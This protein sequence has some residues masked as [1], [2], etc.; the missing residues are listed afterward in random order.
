MRKSKFNLLSYVVDEMLI[1]YESSN[2]KKK[3]GFMIAEI[4]EYNQII[5]L[6]NKFIM[7]RYVKYYSIQICLKKTKKIYLFICF[8]DDDKE[9]LVKFHNVLIDRIHQI[10]GRILILN[11]DNLEAAFLNIFVENISFDINIVPKSNT[12]LLDIE[13]NPIILKFYSVDLDVIDEKNSFIPNFEDF[14]ISRGLESNLV[15]NFFFDTNNTIMVSCY[16]T[17]SI[18][19]NEIQKDFLNQTNNFFNITLLKK[20]KT[21]LKTLGY[22]LWRYKIFEEKAFFED[23][24]NLFQL[25]QKFDFNNL[26]KLNIQFEQ[27]LTKNKIDFNRINDN[28]LLINDTSLFITIIKFNPKIL[29]EILKKYYSKYYIYLFVPIKEIHKKLYAIEKINLLN[30][31]TILDKTDFLKLEFLE[32]FQEIVTME[33]VI[34]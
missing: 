2:K 14:L 24:L 3:I 34:Y 30:K 29:L 12:I 23:C 15:F 9:R 1:F 13:E 4:N 17:E 16:M 26:K 22:C 27:E 28:L 19:Y 21:N 25:R 18:N 31:I 10:D 8:E 7:K 6:L 33:N 20:K 11:N 32:N 5:P